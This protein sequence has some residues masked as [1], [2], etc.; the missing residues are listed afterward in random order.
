MNRTKIE[1]ADFTWNPVTGCDN[2]PSVCAIRQEC[3]ARRLA[4][5]RLRRYYRKGFVPQLHRVRLDPCEGQAPDSLRQDSTIFVCDMGDLFCPGVPDE[6]IKRVL[7]A[8]QRPHN[9]HHRFLLLTKNPK[10]YADFGPWPENC[11]LGA[12]ATDQDDY[13][14]AWDAFMEVM[15]RSIERGDPRIPDFF[16][17]AEPLLEPIQLDEHPL[18]DWLIVGGMTGPNARQPELLW[19]T[20]LMLNARRHQIPYFLK[21]NAP[22][23]DCPRPQ[24]VPWLNMEFTP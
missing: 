2:G 5:G 18:I 4:E 10:R 20:D 22:W 21:N 7:R 17:S 23:Y 24:E 8:V 6:W 9:R 1:W 16:L 19:I 3:Y 12:T 15:A 11:W 13:A 14:R